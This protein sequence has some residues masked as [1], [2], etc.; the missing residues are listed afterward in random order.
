MIV[1]AAMGYPRYKQFTLLFKGY[2]AGKCHF[3]KMGNNDPVALIQ[4]FS[5]VLIV[6]E[7]FTGEEL[8]ATGF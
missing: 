6:M 7:H 2:Y 8:Y 3:Y 5:G 1:Y 4:G